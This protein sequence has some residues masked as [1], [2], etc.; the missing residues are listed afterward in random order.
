MLIFLILTQHPLPD[1]AAMICPIKGAQPQLI[2]FNF[3]Q[4][5]VHLYRNDA[6]IL[7]W[8]TNRTIAATVM[9][10]VLCAAIGAALAPYVVT[11]R[12]MMMFGIGLT[13]LVELTQLTGAWGLY[14]CAWRKFDVDDLM[15]NALGVALG[16]LWMRRRGWVI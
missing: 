7:K 14:P 16:W 4:T 11:W 5:F 9:N 6:A 13:L 2:P 15:M 3:L 8:I 1:R 12:R 10:V